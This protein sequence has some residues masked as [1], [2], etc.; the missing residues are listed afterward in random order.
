MTA[1]ALVFSHASVR[2]EPA[3]PPVLSDIDLEIA[4]GEKVALLGLNGSG[5]TTLLLAAV[6][7]L[8]HEGTITVCGLPLTRESVGEVRRRIGFLFNVPEDQLLFPKVLDDVAFALLHGGVPHAEARA[9]AMDM[10]TAL[11]IG[12]LAQS[13]LHHL[14]HGQ[15]QRVAL[16]GAL[17]SAPPLLLLDEPSAALDPPAK[18]NLARLLAAQPV[19]IVLATH[20]LDFASGLCTRFL[21]LEGGRI[22]LDRTDVREIRQRWDT[23]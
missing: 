16:A 2:Y 14:S 1:P 19:A 21:V 13:S 9:K 17:V 3:E 22:V 23:T 10:L 11:G 4:P 7:L 8:P 5:K 12:Q 18:R 6:G 15:K 20:D